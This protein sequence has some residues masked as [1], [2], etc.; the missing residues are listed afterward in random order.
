MMVR[1]CIRDPF[2][3]IT[4]NRILTSGNGT[5]RT[6][7]WK[8][9]DECASMAKRQCKQRRLASTIAGEAMDRTEGPRVKP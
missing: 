8:N 1:F 6:E 9:A 7:L 3:H 2:N 5:G 4:G